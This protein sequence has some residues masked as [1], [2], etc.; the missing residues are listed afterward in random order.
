MNILFII[1][2]GFDLN[3]GMKTSYADFYKYY[4]KVKSKNDNIAKLKSHISSNN[5]TWADLELELGKYTKNIKQPDELEEVFY[6]ILDSLSKYLKLQEKKFDILKYGG[7]RIFDELGFP[8]KFLL[9]ADRTELYKYKNFWENSRWSV[10]IMSLNYTQTVEKFIGEK[11]INIQIGTHHSSIPITLKKVEHIHGYVDTKMIIGVNDISQIK[12]KRF[13]KNPDILEIIIKNLS[14]QVQKHLIDVSF[15]EKINSANLICVFGSSIGETDK[16]W[17][18]L[19]GER[20]KENCKLIIYTVSDEITNN[21]EQR[22]G[23]IE[24]KIKT[25]FLSKT[26]LKQEEKKEVEKNIYVGINTQMFKM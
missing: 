5:E 14:N 4:K 9:E 2:N 8:E 12:N 23:K 13:H 22:I 20:L 6:D 18:E 15:K 17:W 11:I 16:M 19:I 25:N 21:R 24:R 1:G 26:N 10:N 7:R 3:L